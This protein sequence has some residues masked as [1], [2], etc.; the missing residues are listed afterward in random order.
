MTLFADLEHEAVQSF[1]KGEVYRV[2]ITRDMGTW[3]ASQLIK[4][5]SKIAKI[6]VD[7]VIGTD[8]MSG[9]PRKKV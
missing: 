1:Q 6:K 3:A 4:S 7:I 8:E 9:V 5:A 2:P